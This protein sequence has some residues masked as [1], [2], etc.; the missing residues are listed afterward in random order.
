M[1]RQ[2]LSRFL[3]YRWRYLFAYVGFAVALGTLLVVA[4]FYLPGG[5]SD[6]EINS[7]LISEGLD[8]ARLFELQP[9]QLTYLPY[10]LMQAASIAMFGFTTIGIKLPSV[11][12]GF[13]A[14]LGL[15]YLLNLW[16][17]RN[18]AIITAMVAV[19]TTQFLAAAQAG[20]AGITY[21]TLTVLI[22]IAA[23]MLAR[24]TAYANIIVLTGFVLA[25]ISLY[26]PLN[27]YI[28]LALA[29]TAVF[30]PHA[31]HVLLRQASKPLLAFGFALFLALISPLVIGIMNEP[32]LLL[33]LAGIPT[34]TAT[35]LPNALE[36]LRQY[37]QVYAPV[38]GLTLIPVYGLGVLLLLLLGTYRMVSTKY[39]TKSY[40]L[41][42]WILLLVPLVLLNPA[43]VS[44]T[45]VPVI[46]LL[47]LGIDYLVWSWYRLF[48]KNPYARV[49]GLIP[50]AVLVGGMVVSSIDRYAYGFRYD[51]N[52][53]RS[54]SFDL[55]VL[56]KE[57]RERDER[58][59]L[60]VSSENF[61]LYQAYA[62]HQR[63]ISDITVERSGTPEPGSVTIVERTVRDPSIIPSEI[64]VSGTSDQADRFY[65]YK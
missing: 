63:Y 33:R 26:M 58:V 61:Q 51:D 13:I 19:T 14:A 36:L 7:A 30:H 21:I 37:G 25:A 32:A 57:L 6:T 55:K 46:L 18:V 17:K 39:T 50:L 11:V 24:R 40:I 1:V 62:R 47:G 65:L 43:F 27:A 2:K 31:R 44:I 59:R 4:G 12:L 42:F 5:L 23:S 53:Q 64:L 52:V 8:P 9:E 48:P 15:I 29:F 28:L 16:Y 49:F 3:L 54:Y 35:I 20:E 45:F 34:D 56:S 60:I 22:L 38:T 10:R 41:S